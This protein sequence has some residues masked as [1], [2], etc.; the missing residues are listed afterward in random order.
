MSF[1]KSL[2]LE[3]L[4]AAFVASLVLLVCTACNNGDIQGARPNNPPVQMGGSN[5]PYKGGGDGY[6][7]QKMTTDPKVNGANRA[8]LPTG[9]LV[10]AKLDKGQD[11]DL[12]YS[13]TD[14][15]DVSRQHN[16]GPRQQKG[17]PP[18]PNQRQIVIDRND[19]DAHI[20]EK[21]GEA[22][23]DASSFT[24]DVARQGSQRPEAKANPALGE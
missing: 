4:L 15:K 20:L 17:L 9:T 3:R 7:N 19:P 18:L 24:K 12:L 2:R 6:N 10:A 23:Q 8:A 22:F 5:N 11:P 21:T 14:E 1:L 13:G 16:F